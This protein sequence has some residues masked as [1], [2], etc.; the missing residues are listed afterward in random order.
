MSHFWDSI[1]QPLL[2]AVDAKKIVEIGTEEG[3]CTELLAEYCKKHNAYLH[4]IDIVASNRA[5]RMLENY[6][7]HTTWHVAPSTTV[8]PHILPADVVLIDA[9]HNWYSVLQELRCIERA[10][11]NAGF[12]PIVLVHDTGWPYARR[13]RYGDPHII[14]PHYRQPYAKRGL[15][16]GSLFLEDKEGS[17]VAPSGFHA[18]HEGN[19]RNGVLSALEDFLEET[20]HQLVH[21]KVPG[22]FG[23]SV[24]V[25]ER[26]LRMFPTLASRIE[27]LRSTGLLALLQKV[28]DAR[29]DLFCCC[30]DGEECRKKISTLE[31]NNETLRQE[32]DDLTNAV[33]RE[34][35]L[36]NDAE[37]RLSHLRATRSWRWTHPIRRFESRVRTQKR[38]K[39]ETSADESPKMWAFSLYHSNVGRALGHGLKRLLP[40]RTFSRISSAAKR[41]AGL[42]EQPAEKS[43]T[44]HVRLIGYA[45]AV[46][47]LGH[48][49]RGTAQALRDAGIP[50]Y[51]ESVRGHGSPRMEY[52]EGTL[53]KHDPFDVLIVHVNADQVSL[54]R[55]KIRAARDA[56]KKA[57]GY[58][59]WEL[60]DIPPRFR[61]AWIELDELWVPSSFCA[62]ALQK[63]CPLPVR[64]VPHAV[65]IP[66]VADQTA[67]PTPTNTYSFLYGFDL[68]SSYE[69]KNP[70][71]LVAA[72]RE[73][74]NKEDDVR[75]ILKVLNASSHAEYLKELQKACE[76]SDTIELLTHPMTNAQMGSLMHSCNCYV[77]L[78]RSEGFGLSIAEAMLHGK[79]VIA[80]SFG[81][82]MDF[83]T[84]HNSMPIAWKRT[85]LQ[86][87]IG[88]YHKGAAWAEPDSTKV[89]DAMRWV[90]EHREQAAALGIRAR[91]TI[92]ERYSSTA[93][94]NILR[95]ALRAS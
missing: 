8:L 87:D 24:L 27:E 84:Q 62:T 5:A 30:G 58:W 69:R 19:P 85:E 91:K 3:H 10:A 6:R 94:G 7:E 20:S 22:M 64:V 71:A 65:S 23:I 11:K 14:P 34:R 86:R 18:L 66:P 81:G 74:F 51:L 75:L 80:T 61:S 46:S 72:F 52:D 89:K 68:L 36:A 12:F 38:Q 49:V 59:T 79:P 16:K 32:V 44:T 83:M 48:A 57:I 90:Y 78:H 21:T 92:E 47:G 45:D 39:I 28:E 73:A 56:G 35:R 60:E 50:F 95:E 13:D 70:L 82:N 40:E 9:D 17:G 93:I 29:L 2:Y 76:G 42:P 26:A 53:A 88:V 33:A 1:I 54:L 15:K 55:T 77:S 4:T 67:S 37:Q 25:E 31:R 43:S 63:V 41:T